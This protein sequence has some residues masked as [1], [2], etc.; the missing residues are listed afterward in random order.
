MKAP[1]GLSHGSATGEL[2]EA[3]QGGDTPSRCR[4]RGKRSGLGIGLEHRPAEVIGTHTQQK[5]GE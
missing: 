4:K 2:Q 3:E 5:N 1:E